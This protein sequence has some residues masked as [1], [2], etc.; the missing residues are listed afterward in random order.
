MPQYV[1]KFDPDVK[2]RPLSY[3]SLKQFQK[4]P[5]HFVEYRLTKPQPSAAMEFGNIIDVMILTPD[6][7]ERKYVVMPADLQRPGA[8]ILNAKNPSAESLK[9]IEAWNNWTSQN[10]GKKWIT[11]EDYELAR[12][13][14]EKTFA[15]EKA[16]ELLDRVVRTQDKM[17]WTHKG[18]GLPMIGYKDGT[19][20]TFI[21]DLKT[22]TDGSPENYPTNA[23][24]FGYHIQGGAYLDYESQR[25]K[26]PDFF[27]LVVETTAP[28][29]ISVYK[30]SEQFIALG[31]QE[32]E[33]LL[34][35]FKFCMENDMWYMGYE[36]HT[37]TG[38][39]HL[40]LPSWA[41]NKIN[42]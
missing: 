21:M 13:L 25:G 20:D 28:Y 11:P 19:G 29:N 34:Q 18:T 5:Q 12:F 39:H 3:S 33:Q 32:Y 10:E 14:S 24:K 27:H 36:F 40:D 41:K 30:M 35:S 23:F 4:S 17:E 16:K 26:F 37:A 2:N 7:Y 15:N 9:K 8:N 31:K 6:D 42:K 22:S 1:T 38:Y